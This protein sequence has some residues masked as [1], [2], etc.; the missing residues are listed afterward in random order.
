MLLTAVACT[1][2]NALASIYHDVSFLSQ[3]ANII[4]GTVKWFNVKSGYGF[5]TRYGLFAY[6]VCMPSSILEGCVQ[7][8][9]RGVT[10]NLIHHHPRIR[11]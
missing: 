6:V 5:I 9:F 4:T 8:D 2:C 1:T 3:K 11:V 10:S 7:A